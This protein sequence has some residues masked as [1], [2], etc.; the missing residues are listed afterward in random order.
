MKTAQV[1]NNILGGCDDPI[2]KSLVDSARESSQIVFE[3]GDNGN[4]VISTEISIQIIV[5][6]APQFE[7]FEDNYHVVENDV[8][9]AIVQYSDANED[10]I[11]Y[12]VDQMPS[13]GTYV[14]IYNGL[15]FTSLPHPA[16]IVIIFR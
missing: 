5:N 9:T 13:Y 6:L 16:T 1:Q 2:L 15:E 4:P 8:I 3:V 12:N 11:S 10:P 7:V 14:E